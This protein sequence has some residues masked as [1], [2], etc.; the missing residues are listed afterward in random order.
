MSSTHHLFEINPHRR[1]SM[2]KMM[3]WPAAPKDQDWRDE[4][5]CRD[6]DP[7]LFF[8]VGMGPA[9]QQQVAM[10]K[11][12][13]FTCPSTAK[14]LAWA[15]D[16]GQDAGIWGGTEEGERRAMRRRARSR[17]RRDL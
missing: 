12:V 15:L 10:A 14:C 5:A 17:I 4:A 8:P 2:T 11:S 3:N 7:E 1:I 16:T 13:C 9:I 6:K